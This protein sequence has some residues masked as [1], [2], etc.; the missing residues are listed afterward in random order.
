MQLSITLPDL[1]YRMEAIEIGRLALRYTMQ[2]ESPQPMKIYFGDLLCIEGSST[3][4]TNPAI[5]Y[6]I[7]HSRS[8]LEFLGLG[9][10][11]DS[12]LAVRK[13][14]RCDDLVIEGFSNVHGQLKKVSI[15]QALHHYQGSSDEAEQALAYVIHAANKGLAHT[16]RGFLKHDES[17][18]LLEIAFRGVNALMVNYFYRPMGLDPPTYTLQSRKRNA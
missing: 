11:S 10:E 5:E 17:S 3:G 1:A 13:S 7:L 8:L 15:Q 6:A 4:F 14:A 9:L 2:W 18:R 12:K 16:T